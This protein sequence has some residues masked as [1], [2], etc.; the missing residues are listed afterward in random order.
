MEETKE[1]ISHMPRIGEPAPA[2]EAVTTPGTLKLEDFKGS[3]IMS[4]GRCL[5]LT[6]PT[7]CW[8]GGV[9][10]SRNKVDKETGNIGVT[11]GQ[12]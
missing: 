1:Q 3:C 4:I 2:F 8:R 12:R 10:A 9:I 7:T 6:R 5:S 11:N